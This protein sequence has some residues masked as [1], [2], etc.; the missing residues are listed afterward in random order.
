MLY[1]IYIIITDFFRLVNPPL[2][3]I[4][5]TICQFTPNYHLFLV[6]NTLIFPSVYFSIHAYPNGGGGD[7]TIP[8]KSDNF[9][10]YSINFAGKNKKYVT[11]CDILTIK[12][13]KLLVFF[14]LQQVL[15][16]QLPLFHVKH[17]LFYQKSI[18]IKKV[19]INHT[20]LVLFLFRSLFVIY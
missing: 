11:S 17:Y 9:L 4:I 20:P 5:K 16:Y 12:A 10:T 2:K 7:G 8:L 18:P 3:N 13:L 15:V 1:L 6:V 19:C 14:L